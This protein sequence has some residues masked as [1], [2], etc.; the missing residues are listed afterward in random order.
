VWTE[1]FHRG[2]VN[3]GIAIKITKEE[4]G[5]NTGAATQILGYS[6]DTARVWYSLDAVNG[7]PFAGHQLTVTSNGGG[8]IVWPE[9]KDIGDVTRDSSNEEDV[10]LTIT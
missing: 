10:V 5:I 2:T 1:E 9:G 6:L 8:S 4:G 3:P 7:E